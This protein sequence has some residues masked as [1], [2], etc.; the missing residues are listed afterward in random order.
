[1]V[2]LRVLTGL[3]SPDVYG[4]V[5]LMLGV[6]I[7]ATNVFCQPIL[8]AQLRFF[9]QAVEQGRVSQLRRI[10]SG[11]LSRRVLM[12]VAA[13][14]V[15]GLI[16]TA[17]TK[18]F[19]VLAA[20]AATAAMLAVD[21]VRATEVGLLNADRRQKDFSLWNAA[22]AWAKAAGA[23]LLV[24][25][26]GARTTWVVAGYAAGTIIVNLLFWKKR[27]PIPVERSDEPTEWEASAGPAMLRYARPLVPFNALNWLMSLGDRYFIASISGTGPAGVYAA[28]FG[29]ASQ[30]FIAF[31]AVGTAALRPVVFDAVA[32]RDS[33]TERRTLVRWLA[34]TGGVS[35]AGV[36]AAVA[37]AQPMVN[38]LLG[39]PFRSAVDLIPWI[40]A[41]YAIQNVQ[42]VFE[43]RL[44]AHGRTRGLLLAQVLGTA[45]SI[46]LYLLLIPSHGAWG[47]AV[48]SFLS[49]CS[50]C[51][52]VALMAGPRGGPD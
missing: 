12:V 7:I 1:V 16:W 19:T 38:W 48:A 26:L 32:R 42:Q 50:T 5:A 36:I 4:V 23:V 6:S 44:Y 46:P 21:V 40:A 45:L 37:L 41:T 20:L 29:L 49:M 35:G 31:G 9:A 3:V 33:E 30:P 24:L 39:E 34:L 8:Q 17:W 18:D 2:G 11:V 15:S 28:A 52:A 22:D 14:L 51:T 13:L 47:A 25:M 43:T 27:L 10:V